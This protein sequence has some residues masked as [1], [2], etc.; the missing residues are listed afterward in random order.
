VIT[1]GCAFSNH[2]HQ[3]WQSSRQRTFSLSE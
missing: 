3:M 2:S 1:K